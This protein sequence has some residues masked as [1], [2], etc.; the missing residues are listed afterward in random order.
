MKIVIKSY[1]I[2]TV[3][4]LSTILGVALIVETSCLT[5]LLSSFFSDKAIFRSNSII[6]RFN[7]LSS[8]SFLHEVAATDLNTGIFARIFSNS[9]A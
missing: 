6:C 7:S 4:D 3:D 1:F 9:L 2:L 8:S 5:S